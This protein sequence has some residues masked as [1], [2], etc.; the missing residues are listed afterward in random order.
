MTVMETVTSD[1]YPTR[2]SSHSRRIDR[3]HPTVWPVHSGPISPTELAGH[4]RKGFHV[5]PR[6]LDAA[7]VRRYRYELA[8]LSADPVV[9]ADERAIFEKV[10][11]ELRSIFEVHRISPAISE[12]ISDPRLGGRARQIL[13]TDVYVHQSRVNYM[14]GFKGTG[15]YWH[16]DFETWHA[17]DGMP[18]PRAVSIS[19][20]L[21]DNYP[22]NG[23]LMLMP[24]SQDIYVCCAGETPENNYQ[25]SLQEQQ[26]GTPDRDTL[27]SMV[28]ECGIE[29][30]TG[31]AGSAL[32]FDC[33]VMHG[34]GSNITPYSRSNIFIVFNSV[35]NALVE[36]YAAST[37]RPTFV[38]NRDFLPV[39]G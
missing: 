34:S 38:A 12:L 32:M 14:P 6:L 21:T 1:F 39:A 37:L 9:R 28:R 31:P 5:I 19:I 24:G 17:E 11:G 26:I 25:E 4:A 8:R 10:S 30:F 27:R 29:Q 18:A 15:F 16:S 13:G 7:E 23:G 22:F 36:P 20:A 3:V 2:T 33:N 35:E